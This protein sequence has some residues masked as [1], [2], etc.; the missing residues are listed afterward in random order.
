MVALYILCIVAFAVMVIALIRDPFKHGRGKMLMKGYIIKTDYAGDVISET[1]LFKNGEV[2]CKDTSQFEDERT[3]TLHILEK[4]FKQLE[5]EY[6]ART[7]R[8]NYALG[9][10]QTV[11]KIKNMFYHTLAARE[12]ISMMEELER[13]DFSSKL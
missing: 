5:K 13:E 8:V 7:R 11:T 10:R 2:V 3:A 9:E 6:I 12:V 4:Y 1:V